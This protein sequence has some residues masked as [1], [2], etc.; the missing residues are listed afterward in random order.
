M[1]QRAGKPGESIG[2]N[3][4]IYRLVRRVVMIYI[5]KTTAME[6]KKKK[7]KKD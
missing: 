5:Y 4:K 2:R 7:K 3:N 6:K 1:C